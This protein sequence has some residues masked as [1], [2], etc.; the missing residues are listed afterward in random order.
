MKL[1]ISIASFHAV[2]DPRDGA[3]F[4]LERARAAR[5]AGLDSLFLGD[6]H[7]TPAPYYQNVP[8]LGRLL[9][10]WDERPCGAL[11]L[12]PLWHPVLLAEQVGTLAALARGPF[13]LQCAVG[14]GGRMFDA[15][16]VDPSHRPSRFEQSLDIL[17]RLWRGE[18]VSCDG[19]WS[20]E[21]ARIAP[22]PP[23]TVAVH[24]GAQA[25]VALER[26]ARL[27][28]GWIA[29]PHLVP[30]A[31]RERLR[32]YRSARQEL[33][34]DGGVAVLRRDVY[35]GADAGDVRRTASPV[36]EAG[37]RGFDPAALVV[38]AV[39]EAADQ[40]RAYGE[41]GYDEILIRNLVPDQ[42]AALRCIERLGRVRELL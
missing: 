7:V 8:M 11:F 25:D 2:E 29:S 33:G 41:M 21:G 10:D 20:I 26:A 18:E 35:V 31:A 39:E 24:I 37:Y 23:E 30:D 22:V 36:I 27:G 19:R 40:L 9:A 16:G 12:L 38:G 17:R 28:D 32:R 1:G 14:P 5:D 13:V 42:T 4:V 6:H 15:F 34:H 3:R